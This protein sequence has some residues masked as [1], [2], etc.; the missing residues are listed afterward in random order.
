MVVIKRSCYNPRPMTP[1]TRY[2]FYVLLAGL[3]TSLSLISSEIAIRPYAVPPLLVIILGN[4]IGGALLVASAANHYGDIAL[5]KQPRNL[6]GVLCAA[7]FIYTLGFLASFNAVGLVGSGKVALLG[8]LETVFVVTLAILFLGERLTPLRWLAGVIALLGVLLINFDVQA[9]RFTL[10]RG[11][12]LATAA[13]LAVASGIIIVKPV[14]D[15][16]DARLITGLA[17][18]L[19]GVFLTPLLPLTGTP[20]TLSGAA[21]LVIIGGGIMRGLAWLFYNVSLRHIGAARCAIIF[22]SYAFFAV[23]LQIIIVQLAPGLGLQ[24]PSN[25][26]AAI[27]G[28]LLVALGIAILQLESTLLVWL[29][30]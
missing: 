29:R 20:L 7:L 23:T 30:R 16:A 24:L 27:G 14:L 15:L 5:L 22:L 2:S 17:L 8:Q 18:L 12:L 28:G 1:Q 11:E 13:P 6:V 19:G 4:F 26:V 25:L 9:L 3:T 21:L 10:S